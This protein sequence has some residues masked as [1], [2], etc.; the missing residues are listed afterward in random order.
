MATKLLLNNRSTMWISSNSAVK[1][2][3]NVSDYFRKVCYEY[4]KFLIRIEHAY[5]RLKTRTSDTV[6]KRRYLLLVIMWLHPRIRM[7]NV[8]YIAQLRLKNLL[9]APY[10]L[11]NLSLKLAMTRIKILS[12]LLRIYRN[13]NYSRTFWESINFDIF[14]VPS[15]LQLF[16]VEEAITLLITLVYP[17]PLSSRSKMKLMITLTS[18]AKRK[19]IHTRT[20]YAY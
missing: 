14:E 4:K 6:Y 15:M 5:K 13:L 1:Y 8:K 7:R 3:H 9:R 11:L 12:Y 2:I 19:R 10:N 18:A 20:H 17:S 16:P